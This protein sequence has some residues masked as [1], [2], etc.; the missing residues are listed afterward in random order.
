LL[1]ESIEELYGAG[2]FE[3]R[4]ATIAQDVV[5]RKTGRCVGQAI[6]DRIRFKDE[7]GN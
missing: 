5:L 1:V 3:R 7:D 4:E 6:N 2:V